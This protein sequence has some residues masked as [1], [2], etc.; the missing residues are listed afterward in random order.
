MMCLF[1]RAGPTAHINMAKQDDW[2][3]AEGSA[4]LAVDTN[5]DCV[6]PPEEPPVMPD[7]SQDQTRFR[8]LLAAF[9]LA[10]VWVPT[11]R[12]RCVAEGS[13]VQDDHAESPTAL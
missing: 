9:L 11:R 2:R 3:Q 6:K 13:V 1:S 7:V 10:T 5:R 8:L 12:L 4:R